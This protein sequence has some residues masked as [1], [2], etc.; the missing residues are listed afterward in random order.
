ME[1]A[2]NRRQF[3]GAATAVSIGAGARVGIAAAMPDIEPGERPDQAPEITVLNPYGRVPVSFIID[4]S[5][6]LVNMGHYCLPQFQ[7]AW[8]RRERGDRYDKPWRSW[9]REI[10]DAFVRQFGEFCRDQGVKGKYSIVPYPACVG[11]LDRELPGWSR[12]QLRDS[13]ALVRELMVPDWDIHPEMISHTRVIDLQT[14]RPLPQ[15]SDGSYWMENG[16]WDNGRSLDEIAAYITY[17]LN[18]IKNL[19]FPCEGFTT[20]VACWG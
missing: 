13:L 6:C 17:A 20:P 16:G 14:G 7:E 5:T 3:I 1:S 4:D 19:D 11:W 10:P 8:G 2:I 18:L 9:P 15:R 12:R